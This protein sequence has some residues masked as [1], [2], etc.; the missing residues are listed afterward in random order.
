MRKIKLNVETLR[1]ESFTPD[2]GPAERGTVVGHVSRVQEGCVYPTAVYHSCQPGETVD[3]YTCRCLYPDTDVRM[4]C[5][6]QGC[7]GGGMC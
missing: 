3:Q 2:E 4:C 7:S 6:E 1:V 5:S